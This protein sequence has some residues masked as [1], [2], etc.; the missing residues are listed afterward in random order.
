MS[1]STVYYAGHSTL[2]LKKFIV[3]TGPTKLWSVSIFVKSFAK[4][5]K[6]L[7]VRFLETKVQFAERKCFTL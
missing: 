3:D 1:S 5:S 6:A 7:C 2:S 4:F